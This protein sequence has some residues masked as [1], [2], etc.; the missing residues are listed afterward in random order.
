MP[1]GTCVVLTTTIVRPGADPLPPGAQGQVIE[2]DAG[3]PEL[4]RVMF[5]G[6]SPAIL[7][8]QSIVV[9]APTVERRS[10]AEPAV[11][12][13][14]TLPQLAEATLLPLETAAGYCEDFG[15]YLN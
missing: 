2:H 1:I 9:Q 11:V 15:D 14:L 7:V 6:H 12:E 4:Y 3:R 5:D 10:M 13:E 8:H